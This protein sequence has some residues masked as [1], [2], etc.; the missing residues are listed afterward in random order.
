[1]RILQKHYWLNYIEQLLYLMN[2]I[3]TELWK[4]VVS[5]KVFKRSPSYSVS[6]GTLSRWHNKE[7]VCLLSSSFL[8]AHNRVILPSQNKIAK[9][10]LLKFNV[11]RCPDYIR[12]E[13]VHDTYLSISDV[14]YSI[15][16]ISFNSLRLQVINLAMQKPSEH[17]LTVHNKFLTNAVFTFQ[18]K[19]HKWLLSQYIMWSLWHLINYDK[20]LQTQQAISISS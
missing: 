9:I 4:L 17:Y 8:L 5:T 16:H 3:Q 15:N 10:L 6:S 7:R 12:Y 20:F 11:Q 19:A 18:S 13:C 1:M 2:D 14:S